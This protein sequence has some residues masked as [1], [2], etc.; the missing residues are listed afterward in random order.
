MEFS[1]QGVHKTTFLEFMPVSLFPLVSI[2]VACL[3]YAQKQPDTLHQLLAA[4]VLLVTTTGRTRPALL[5]FTFFLNSQAKYQQPKQ[6]MP[7]FG[8]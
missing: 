5:V 3:R 2:S 8:L 4:F 7:G 6:M 1:D